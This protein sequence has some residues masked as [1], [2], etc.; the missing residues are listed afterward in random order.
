MLHREG[1]DAN[2]TEHEN[3]SGQYSKGV[4]FSG[5]ES[6]YPDWRL[7]QFP[8]SPPHTNAEAVPAT[9]VSFSILSISLFTAIQ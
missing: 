7:S 1:H 3:P 6:A 5:L 2:T 9:I 8:Q 4:W